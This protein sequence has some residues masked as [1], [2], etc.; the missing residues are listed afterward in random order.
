MSRSARSLSRDTASLTRCLDQPLLRGFD[1]LIENDVR[2]SWQRLLCD[3]PNRLAVHATDLMLGCEE[4][5][6]PLGEMDHRK[7]ASRSVVAALSKVDDDR[8][9]AFLKS[10]IA[11]LLRLGVAI[12]E[13]LV[14][15]GPAID[16]RERRL[17]VKET[18]CFVDRNPLLDVIEELIE[19]LGL[20]VVRL[21]VAAECLVTRLACRRWLRALR[22]SLSASQ[23]NAAEKSGSYW[24]LCSLAM[25]RNIVEVY[26]GLTSSAALGGELPARRCLRKA[27]FSSAV[28]PPV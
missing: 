12:R 22:L 3:E 28:T 17:L 13:L 4:G 19:R 27:S 26:S 1:Q 11:R 8:A 20:K 16:L 7:V 25:L 10:G 14:A 5:V 15:I 18:R 6:A 2:Q 21:D 23:E 9:D 24:R